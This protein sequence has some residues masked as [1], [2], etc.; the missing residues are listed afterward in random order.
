M[1]KGSRK[2]CWR[3]LKGREQKKI[4]IMNEGKMIKEHKMKK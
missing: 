1:K 2:E 4:N 3:S